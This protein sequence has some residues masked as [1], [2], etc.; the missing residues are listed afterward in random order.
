MNFTHAW[1]PSDKST[2]NGELACCSRLIINAL[3]QSYAIYLQW[4]S[5]FALDRGFTSLP[6]GGLHNYGTSSPS[7]SHSSI[8]ASSE[9]IELYVEKSVY[10]IKNILF[11]MSVYYYSG[12]VV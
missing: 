7:F 6:I 11:K 1:P 3:Q 10:L 2:G 5:N 4:P 12:T 9:N 8:T